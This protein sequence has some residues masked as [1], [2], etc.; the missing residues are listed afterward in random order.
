MKLF[1]SFYWILYIPLVK[2]KENF[3]CTGDPATC[4]EPYLVC[5]GKV[6]CPW[7]AHYGTDR[8]DEDPVLCEQ[9]RLVLASF[10]LFHC[11]LLVYKFRIFTYFLCTEYSFLMAGQM[12]LCFVI[13][14]GVARPVMECRT[15]LTSQ[16][17]K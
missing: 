15:V 14:A 12:E 9:C 1:W 17:K 3:C 5:N 13:L 16:T 4:L 10:Y 2:G 6:N 11:Q 7:T 8:S